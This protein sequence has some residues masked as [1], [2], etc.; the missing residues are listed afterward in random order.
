MLCEC[1]VH[2]VLQQQDRDNYH[3]QARSASISGEPQGVNEAEREREDGERER[4]P[5]QGEKYVFVSTRL[6]VASQT[7]SHLLLEICRS[8][9]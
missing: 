2:N 6:F 7:L 9:N 1:A 3:N 5:A 8:Q 4:N